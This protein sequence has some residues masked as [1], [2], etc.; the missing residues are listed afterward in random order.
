MSCCS[1]CSWG[2][3]MLDGGTLCISYGKDSLACI[4]AC[5]HLGWKIKRIVHAEVWATDTI[6]AELPPMVEFKKKA[7][8]IIKERWGLEVE[9]Y[10]SNVTYEQQFYTTYKEG[11]KVGRIYGF[12]YQR[13][14]WCNSRLKISAVQKCKSKGIEFVGIAADEPKR[15]K[16]L[17]DKRLS[18]LKEIGWDE[19]MCG[20]WCTY[21]DL[22]SPNYSDFNRGGCWFC[23]NQGVDEL[24][25]LR[26]NYPEHWDLLMKWDKD[27]PVPF[28]P[29]GHTVHDF[30][31]RFQFE[32]DGL[33]PMD[34]TF[35]WAMLEKPLQVSFS[36][37]GLIT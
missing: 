14:P 21:S 10:R 25:L 16:I 17:N 12:P 22:L 9:H 18:P 15:F 33:V 34:K 2:A 3:A 26:K 23:H 20:L 27:S 8:A 35:R 36:G 13:G 5:H 24:R 19:D 29:D 7:D 32:D 1:L 4:G 6:P 30:D 11:V 28:K 31:R 37:L